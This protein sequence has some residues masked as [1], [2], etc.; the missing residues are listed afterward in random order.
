[1]GVIFKRAIN[2]YE[3]DKMG[4]VHHANYL[5][6]LEEARV[7]F[8]NTNLLSYA[9]LEQKG[10]YSP[11]SKISITYKKPVTYG[12]TIEVDTVLSEVTPVRFIFSYV[13]K[14]QKTGALVA[15]AT[16]EHCFADKNGHLLILSRIDKGLFDKLTSLV[17]KRGE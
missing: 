15:E 7:C 17:E 6:Y 8:L 11:T 5:H 16:S 1:M 9:S 4:I 12:D 3:T 13:I 10:I 2:Y 14:E